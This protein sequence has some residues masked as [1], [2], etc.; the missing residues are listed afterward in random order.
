MASKQEVRYK[1]EQ[2]WRAMEARDYDVST[3]CV[4]ARDRG[5][6]SAVYS[7]VVHKA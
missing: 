5:F 1:N 4:Q 3:I 6:G 2:L 7:N